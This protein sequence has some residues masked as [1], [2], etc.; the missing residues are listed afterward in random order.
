MRRL[1]PATRDVR[2]PVPGASRRLRHRITV[3]CPSSRP[4]ADLQ[5]SENPAFTA[6]SGS[7]ETR[8]RTGDTTIFSRVLYQLSYLASVLPKASVRELP[9]TRPAPGAG[10]AARSRDA[11]TSV[12]AASAQPEHKKPSLTP[13]MAINAPAPTNDTAKANEVQVFWSANS[14]PCSDSGAA[15]LSSRR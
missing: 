7:G 8:T 1:R 9:P 2:A 10:Q 11:D 3:L 6:T 13:P 4:T 12:T 15:S 5:G 14:R